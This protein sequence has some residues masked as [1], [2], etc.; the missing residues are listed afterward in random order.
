MLPDF[1]DRLHDGDLDAPVA[2]EQLTR[3]QAIRQIERRR[4][5]WI[6]ATTGTMLMIIVAVIWAFAEYHNAG[7]WPT[8]GFS[9]SSGISHVWNYWIIYPAIVWVVLTAAD[10][11]RVFWRRPITETEIKREIDRQA[12]EQKRAA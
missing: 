11:V 6:R 7:G 3:Q 4:R 5:F 1:H 10:A 12:G 2:G 8:K 9:Q